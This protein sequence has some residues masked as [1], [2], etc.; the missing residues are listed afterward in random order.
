MGQPKFCEIRIAVYGSLHKKREGD[1]AHAD[2]IN[3]GHIKKDYWLLL[4]MQFF[5]VHLAIDKKTFNL[6]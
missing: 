5:K 3:L 2:R 6:L 4:I 1:K